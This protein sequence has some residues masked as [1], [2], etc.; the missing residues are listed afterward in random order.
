M[1]GQKRVGLPD[2]KRQSSP[3][4]LRQ[5][6]PVISLSHF[7]MGH[8]FDVESTAESCALLAAHVRPAL[9]A[10]LGRGMLRKARGPF[11]SCGGRR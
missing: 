11:F 9:A 7:P 8:Q 4:T 6:N 2:W 10:G 5:H 3:S 1:T